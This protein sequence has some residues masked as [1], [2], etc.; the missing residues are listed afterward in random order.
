M[1]DSL[2]AR[3]PPGTNNDDWQSTIVSGTWRLLYQLSRESRKRLFDELFPA[4]HDAKAEVMGDR[5]NNCYYLGYIGT[6][7]NARRKGYATRLLRHMID[8]VRTSTIRLTEL[9]LIVF[10]ES[11]K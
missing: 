8:K 2:P 5:N 4:L 7:A 9:A 11:M 1:T 3:M 10:F 6:K